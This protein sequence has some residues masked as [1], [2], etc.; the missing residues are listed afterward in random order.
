MGNSGSIQHCFLL[1]YIGGGNKREKMTELAIRV[2]PRVSP[3]EGQD[4]IE[5]VATNRNGL[6]VRIKIKR[7]YILQNTQE[8]PLEITIENPKEA[9]IQKI[10][11]EFIRKCE[12]SIIN[13][14]DVLINSTISDLSNCTDEHIHRSIVLPISEKISNLL[15]TYTKS[16]KPDQKVTIRIFYI[17]KIECCVKGWFNNIKFKIPIF[18]ANQEE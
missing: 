8:L 13:S 9:N 1:E 12:F 10:K 17:L 4:Q 6:I 16:L 18:V 11:Y 7:A 3:P 5:T 14:R 15:P 2:L